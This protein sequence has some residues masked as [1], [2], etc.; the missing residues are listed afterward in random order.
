M[1]IPLVVVHNAFQG[2]HIYFYKKSSKGHSSKV[3]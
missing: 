3:T 1:F 2:A